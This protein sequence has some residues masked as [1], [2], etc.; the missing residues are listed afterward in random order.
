MDTERQTLQQINISNFLD[1]DGDKTID[2]NEINHILQK[3]HK[4]ITDIYG[5]VF[6]ENGVWFID[7]YKPF[8]FSKDDEWIPFL[9]RD[10]VTLRDC[11]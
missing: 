8:N 1:D 3:A 10:L 9:I 4:L 2:N 5:D 6:N 11:M 7:D